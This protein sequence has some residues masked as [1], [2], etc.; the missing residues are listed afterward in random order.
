LHLKYKLFG[1]LVVSLKEN[2]E[3]EVEG[4]RGC[5]ITKKMLDMD[6]SSYDK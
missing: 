6:K 2:K 4:C 5:K 3:E 1:L